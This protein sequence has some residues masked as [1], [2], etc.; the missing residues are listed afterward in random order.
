[1]HGLHRFAVGS[2]VSG[3]GVLRGAAP[4][5]TNQKLIA[6]LGHQLVRAGAERQAHFNGEVGVEDFDA[7]YKRQAG[8]DLQ[9]H[10][11]LETDGAEVDRR[12][13]VMRDTFAARGSALRVIDIGGAAIVEHAHLNAQTQPY[14]DKAE[15]NRQLRRRKADGRIEGAR[16]QPVVAIAVHD[17]RVLAPCRACGAVVGILG[18]A[19]V[20]L[21][22]R[23][24]DQHGRGRKAAKK[25]GDK[26]IG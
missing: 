13:A 5:R 12:P 2:R 17:R 19:V 20:V 4:L 7:A 24:V 11:Q 18:G 3:R 1:M 22:R 9:G 16:I 21:F 25:V 26:V 6:S 8:F 14:G 15:I 10:L 23:G